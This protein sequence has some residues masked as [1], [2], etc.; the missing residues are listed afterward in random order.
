MFIEPTRIVRALSYA[1][2]PD[3]LC[4]HAAQFQAG[5]ALYGY[6]SKPLI[7]DL[8]AFLAGRHVVEAF[9]GRGHLSALLR[10]RGVEIRPTSLRSGHDCSGTLGHVLDVED[11]SVAEAVTRYRDWMDVLLVC[12]PVADDS[13]RRALAYL[14]DGCLIVFIG[15]VTDYTRKPFAFLGGCANDGFFEAVEERHDLTSQL[16]YPTFRQDQIKVYMPRR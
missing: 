16:R 13:L 5:E 10:E 2:L 11:L 1:D 8:S 7:D 12:W 14:P 6:L 3:G 9:A 15:E 4:E